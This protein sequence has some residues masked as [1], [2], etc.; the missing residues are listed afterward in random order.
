[1][2]K[3]RRAWDEA[4]LNAK[5]LAVVF[6]ALSVGVLIGLGEA[7]T[8]HHRWP[9]LL[10]II[11]VSTAFCA[12]TRAWLTGPL[13]RLLRRLEAV[14]LADGDSSA[15][16]GL[17]VARR[18]ELGR[19]AKVVHR[20][21]VAAVQHRFEANRL[22]RTLD[23]RVSEAT[24]RA[25]QRLRHMAF[26]DPLTEL[27]NRR[28]LDEQLDA[29]VQSVRQSPDFDLL[30]I[31]IDLDDFKKLNDTQGHAAGDDLLVLLGTLIRASIRDDDVA[32]RLGG[33]EFAVFLPSQSMQRAEQFIT[34]VRGLF[35]QR[36][37]A[38]HRAVRVDLSIGVASMR[39][40][41]AATGE[42]LLERADAQLY[43]AKHAGKGQTVGLEQPRLRYHD[44][45]KNT[46]PLVS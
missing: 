37:R 21:G 30:C 24:Q 9:M 33:D 11:A 4:P 15:L 20:V 39:R 1:M 32:V 8:G 19:I 46:T 45:T 18:D 40:D 2:L 43:A 41:H 26:R 17:P 16:S 38:L 27:G 42:Q 31:M 44:A 23:S 12:A 25:T 3:H 22:R 7:A 34:S 36:A 28:F 14:E 35:R 6:A 10:G 13:D 5:V 29:L